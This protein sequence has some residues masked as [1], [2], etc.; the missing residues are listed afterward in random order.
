MKILAL[1]FDLCQL[2]Y[3]L[4]FSTYTKIFR[5]LLSNIP[6]KSLQIVT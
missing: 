6:G 2:A 5:A 3:V 4:L 1:N